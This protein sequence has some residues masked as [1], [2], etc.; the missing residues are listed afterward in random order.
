MIWLGGWGVPCFNIRTYLLDLG[1]S[2]SRGGLEFTLHEAKCI[3]V[4]LVLLVFP[5]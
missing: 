3:S 2:S 5:P 4:A 1:K